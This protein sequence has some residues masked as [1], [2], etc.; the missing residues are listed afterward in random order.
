MERKYLTSQEVE[1]VYNIPTRTLEDWRHRGIGP[2]YHKRGK[3]VLYS[4]V[5]L[6]AFFESSRVLTAD[7]RGKVKAVR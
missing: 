1:Q 5:T 2:S 7:D 4:V 3:R 6:D